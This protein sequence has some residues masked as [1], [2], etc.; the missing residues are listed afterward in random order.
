M[1][2]LDANAIGAIKMKAIAK[3]LVT[4]QVQNVLISSERQKRIQKLEQQI[5]DFGAK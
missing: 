3:G 1:S 2:K 4:Q 5:T